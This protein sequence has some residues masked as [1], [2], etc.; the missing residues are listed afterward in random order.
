MM[1]GSRSVVCRG[2]DAPRVNTPPKKRIATA[3]TMTQR[4]RAQRCNFG[5]NLSI[6]DWLFGTAVLPDTLPE[7]FGLDDEA[8]PEGNIVRQF[9]YAFRRSL[10]SAP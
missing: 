7:A 5:N 1:L 10:P 3:Q 6:F 9:F 8:Y 4:S 2:S